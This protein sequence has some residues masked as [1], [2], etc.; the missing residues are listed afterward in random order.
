MGVVGS[1]NP[2]RR[3]PA[4]SI[5]PRRTTP[6]TELHKTGRVGE[7]LQVFRRVHAVCGFGV[8]PGRSVSGWSGIAGIR[9]IPAI[10]DAMENI[11]IGVSPNLA[12]CLVIFAASGSGLEARFG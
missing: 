7:V 8:V 6:R 1:R 5:P 4:L 11:P 12:G 3:C 10:P 2:N 9:P